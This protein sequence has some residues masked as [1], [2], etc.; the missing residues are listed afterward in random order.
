ML[1]K[2]IKYTDYDGVE[3]EEKFYFN[4]NRAELVEM[5]LKEEGGLAKMIDKIVA[6]KDTPRVIE[7]FKVLIL[8]AYGEKSPDGKRFI[9]SKELSEAFSQTEA[10]VEMFI[11]LGTDANAGAAFING[12]LPSNLVEDVEK[13]AAIRKKTDELNKGE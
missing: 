13:Q 10:Y 4:F 7:L 5:E 2:N 11:E 8:D 1:V 6:E 9:K 12:V 3:R